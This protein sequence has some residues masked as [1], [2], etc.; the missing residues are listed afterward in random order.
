MSVPA[1]QSP[2]ALPV[3]YLQGMKQGDRPIINGLTLV[4]GVWMG[5]AS[6]ACPADISEIQLTVTDAAGQRWS[7]TGWG[8]AK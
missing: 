8:P 2:S 6:W 3:L 5:D 7:P 4:D 1:N